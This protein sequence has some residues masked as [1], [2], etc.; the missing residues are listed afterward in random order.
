MRHESGEYQNNKEGKGRL[1]P[2]RAKYRTMLED[3]AY[4]MI[5]HLPTPTDHTYERVSDFL[6]WLKKTDI[7]ARHNRGVYIVKKI[8]EGYSHAEIARQLG[9]SAGRVTHLLTDFRNYYHEHE[10]KGTSYDHATM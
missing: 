8:L 7:P 9:I 3:E 10:R 4:D 6:I 1:F 2:Q 5:A